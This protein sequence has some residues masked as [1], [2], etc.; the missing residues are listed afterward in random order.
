MFFCFSKD[1][2][3]N[4]QVFFIPNPFNYSGKTDPNGFYIG[5]DKFGS[6]VLVDF[7]HRS[8]DKTNANILILGNSVQGK[9]QLL[10]L[11]LCNL[12][13]AGMHIISLFSFF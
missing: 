11:I 8:D 7:N 5:R 9:S 4:Q 12:R 2:L 13:E 6:N 1:L 10:K 3:K